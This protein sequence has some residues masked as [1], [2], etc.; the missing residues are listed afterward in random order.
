MHALIYPCITLF[1]VY[2]P[3]T[4]ASHTNDRQIAQWARIAD[5]KIKYALLIITLSI[6]LNDNDNNTA[7]CLYNIK[8]WESNEIE[9]AECI[10][11]E[12]WTQ[13]LDQYIDNL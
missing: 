11:R 10:H 2:L 6:I 9:Y 13:I 12:H 4:I 1:R 5:D 7:R 8:L 3:S